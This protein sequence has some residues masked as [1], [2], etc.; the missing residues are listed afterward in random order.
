[1]VVEGLLLNDCVAE[2]LQLLSS[3]FP[4]RAFD[5]LCSQYRFPQALELAGVRPGVELN[6]A[7]LDQLPV[8]RRQASEA[9]LQRFEFA[10]SVARTLHLLGQPNRADEVLALLQ[11]YAE[12]QPN[13]AHGDAPQRQCW[14]RLAAVLVSLGQA[15]RGWG[16]AERALL[17]PE[18]ATPVL[19]RLYPQ[20]WR[21]AGAWWDYFRLRYRGEPPGTLRRVYR[22]LQ[23]AAE[24]TAAAFLEFAAETEKSAAALDKPLRQRVA[25]ALGEACLRRGQLDAARRCLEPLAAT[26]A[27]ARERLADALRR[28]ERWPEAAEQY[29][30]LWEQNRTQLAALFLAGDAAEL[31]RPRRGRPPAEGPGPPAGPGQHAAARRWP[32][33]C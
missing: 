7:W 14:E 21:D 6:R 19:A 16:L 33:P 28:S 27:T 25:L 3:V 22:L 24:E 5:L 10:L 29:Q 1:M 23:P 15:E 18:A 12:E 17:T 8:S 9:G 32:R 13:P 11:S 2:G 20:Q 4:E 30:A 31:C 26:D